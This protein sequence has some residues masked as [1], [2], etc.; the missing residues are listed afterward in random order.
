MECFFEVGS[1][2]L[3]S[4]AGSAFFDAI[5]MRNDGLAV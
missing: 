5:I 2:V 3:D 1:N 4:F